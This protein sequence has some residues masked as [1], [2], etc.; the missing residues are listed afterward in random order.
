MRNAAKFSLIKIIILVKNSVKKIK[1]LA[2]NQHFGQKSTFYHSG[3]YGNL[4]STLALSTAA[5]PGATTTAPTDDETFEE[6]EIHMPTE[7]SSGCGADGTG[8]KRRYAKYG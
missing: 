5:T 7:F 3:A 1:N 4:F 8:R 6:G 2:K